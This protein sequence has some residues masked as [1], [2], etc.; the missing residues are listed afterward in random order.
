MKL[1][2]STLKVEQALVGL[3]KIQ[4]EL[5]WDSSR[6]ANRGRYI[7]KFETYINEFLFDL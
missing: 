4:F 2:T 1:D 7:E 5:L 3:N 6:N